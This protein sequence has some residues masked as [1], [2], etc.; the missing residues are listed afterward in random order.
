M[1][2]WSISSQG[3]S[4]EKFLLAF[5]PI[6]FAMDAFG[7]LPIFIGLTAEMDRPSR[8]KIIL[9][10]IVTAL[11]VAIGFIFLGDAVFRLMGVTV[12]DFMVA[13]GA[14]LF[15]ISTM[16]VALGTK[17]ARQIPSL[18]AVPLGTPLLVGPAV[19]TT[20]L[21]L[22]PVY[23]TVAVVA[24]VVA[25]IALACAVLMGANSL[26]RLLGQAGSK[27]VSKVASLLLAAI[28]VM[29]IRKGLTQIILSASS[30]GAG[31]G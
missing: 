31:H 1:P 22:V 8:R 17:A 6:F 30:T 3:E 28:A 26:E 9:E 29:L 7:V 4:M 13:G 18:G 12:Y 27:A 21:I 14:I 2:P 16:D 23:G 20:S 15:I 24:A 5:V 11:V 10:S 19:L 25:N